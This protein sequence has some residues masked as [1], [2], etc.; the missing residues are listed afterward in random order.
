MYDQHPKTAS[1]RR[2]PEQA[3]RS[4]ERS[5]L[6]PAGPAQGPGL[7]SSERYGEPARAPEGPASGIRS[8]TLLVARLRGSP[9][10]TVM[11]LCV[12]LTAREPLVSGV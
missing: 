11:R 2:V 6:S 3:V 8:A 4:A 1:N 7:Q 10:S 9:L 12:H 5:T